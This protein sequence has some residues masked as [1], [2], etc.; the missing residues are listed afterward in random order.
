MNFKNS[1][2]LLLSFEKNT[3]KLIE[4]TKTRPNKLWNLNGLN[5]AKHLL[6]RL[7]F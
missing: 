1:E 2:Q 6:T 3:D 7:E 4:Q 5:L